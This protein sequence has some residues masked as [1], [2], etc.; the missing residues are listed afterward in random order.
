MPIYTYVCAKCSAEVEVMAN[1]KDRDAAIVHEGC[2]GDLKRLVQI[3][4]TVMGRPGYQMQAV[5]AN[6]SHVKG[7]F[8]KEAKRQRKA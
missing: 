1:L 4:R 7:H 8:G 2:G 6:G 3:E 5:L